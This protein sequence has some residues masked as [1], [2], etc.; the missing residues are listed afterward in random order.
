MTVTPDQA[1]ILTTLALAC[2]PLGAARWDSAGVMAAIKRV[3]DRSL[4]EV[5]M[6][7]IRA[8]SDKGVDSPGVIPSAGSHWQETSGVRPSAPDVR[9]RE[10]RCSVCSRLKGD[11]DARRRTDP[12][13]HAFESDAH[14]AQRVAAA[15][16]ETVAA[17]VA[18]V[19]DGIEPTTPPPP[20]KTLTDLAANDPELA[21]RVETLRTQIPTEPPKNAPEEAA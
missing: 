17:Q 16:P 3:S 8:A 1:R 14:A 12:D 9:P 11:C 6:A 20:D 4:A 21:A 19:R 2:R 13:P 15:D 10:N 18:A 5:T 7:V